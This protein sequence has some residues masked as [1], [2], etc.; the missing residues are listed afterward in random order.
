MSAVP[1]TCPP[2]ADRI[3]KSLLGY[4]VI[5]GPIYLLVVAAQAIT[6]TGFTPARHDVSLLANGE[7]GWIQIANFVLTGAMTIAA[8]IGVGRAFGVDRAARR[9]AALIAGYG[10][11]LVGAGVFRADP[12]MG[13]PPGTPAGRGSVSWHGMLHLLCAGVGFASFVVAC[14]VVAARFSRAGE[15]GW[16]WYSRLSGAL[17]A[18]GF[19]AVAS[20]SN[21]P[22]VVLFFTAAVVIAWAWLTAISIKLYRLVGSASQPRP[23]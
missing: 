16:A 7:L 5:A 13:F 17:F 23:S 3:T 22:A 8:A 9:A 10:V 11:G 21:S 6:R 15:G 2:L 12:S 14:F 19:A 1:D 4:G 20:G 18:A